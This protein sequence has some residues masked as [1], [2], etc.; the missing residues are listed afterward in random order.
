MKRLSII[1]LILVSTLSM[2]NAQTEEYVTL[3]INGGI[4]HNINGY[5]M[6]KNHNGETF[7]N[8]IPGYNIALDLG[9]K[10]SAKTR[11]RFEIEHEEF[12][13][14]AIW[15]TTNLSPKN[16]SPIYETRV[17]VWN[18]GLNLRL[19][20]KYFENEKWKLFVSP[21]LLYEF[22]INRETLNLKR[23]YV[24]PNIH[25]YDTYSYKKYPEIGAQNPEHILGGNV[26]FLCKYK[27]AKHVAITLTPEYN[28][29]FRG[30][31]KDNY[32]KPYQRLTM[33][34]GF[35]FNF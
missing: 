13:Y 20:Y 23:H 27:I 21:G 31:V 16:L 7:K 14:K 22:N 24:N 5:K 28:I 1:A 11:F 8:G 18:M 10:T 34:G 35:E 29:F 33:N 6:R 9:I 32:G 15:D 19:D 12:H 25:K 2:T 17:K 4:L 3:G 30:I 26:Q